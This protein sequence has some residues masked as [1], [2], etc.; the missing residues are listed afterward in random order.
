[1][2][3]HDHTLVESVPL[4]V[5]RL[6]HYLLDMHTVVMD[7]FVERCEQ[8]YRLNGPPVIKGINIVIH[9]PPDITIILLII[10]LYFNIKYPL[11][12]NRKNAYL[13]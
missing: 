12:A 13:L 6:K 4:E 1:M 5:S 7:V 9:V 8:V 2:C 10:I 11:T 3:L